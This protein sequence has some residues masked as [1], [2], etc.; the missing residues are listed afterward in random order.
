MKRTLVG[1]RNSG[2]WHKAERWGDDKVAGCSLIQSG[3]LIVLDQIVNAG[4]TAVAITVETDLCRRC[5]P[6]G[7]L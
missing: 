4:I 2:K 6:E 7:K 5:Y 3:P 1:N